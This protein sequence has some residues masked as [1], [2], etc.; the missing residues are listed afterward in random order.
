M[1]PV[2]WLYIV[3]IDRFVLLPRILAWRID[4]GYYTSPQEWN[5]IRRKS[6]ISLQERSELW[7]KDEG[8]IARALTYADDNGRADEQQVRWR[9]WIMDDARYACKTTHWGRTTKIKVLAFKQT[10]QNDEVIKK[11]GIILLP[12]QPPTLSALLK[13]PQIHGTFFR[14]CTEL[15][16]W[17]LIPFIYGSLLYFRQVRRH[18]SCNGT[19]NE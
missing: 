18:F 13:I 8:S 11:Q 15:V 19:G 12:T 17:V 5:R 16:P 2:L 9:T 10:D 14:T 3:Y 4:D 1:L 7:R 6:G